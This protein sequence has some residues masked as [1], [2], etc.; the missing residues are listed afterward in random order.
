MDD[1][2]SPVPQTDERTRV[3]YPQTTRK[4]KRFKKRVWLPTKARMIAAREDLTPFP[5]D[6]P[7]GILRLVRDIVSRLCP[8]AHRRI[9]G[10]AIMALQVSSEDLLTEV[11]T[12]MPRSRQPPFC[13]D[14]PLAWTRSSQR[15]DLTDDDIGTFREIARR[16][17]EHNLE[18]SKKTPNNRTKGC[19][20]GLSTSCRD[21]TPRRRVP[22]EP[23]ALNKERRKRKLLRR[24]GFLC[25]LSHA[26]GSNDQLE[27][28]N[29]P[30]EGT[31]SG[32]LTICPQGLPMQMIQDK[33]G[34]KEPTNGCFCSEYEMSDSNDGPPINMDQERDGNK[35]PI[36]DLLY[37]DYEMSD[38]HAASI[39]A[40]MRN[41]DK[42]SDGSE[43][44]APSTGSYEDNHDTA[45][46]MLCKITAPQQRSDDSN[47]ETS[48]SS[49]DNS[50]QRIEASGAVQS[51]HSV[52]ENAPVC[53][54]MLCHSS[55]GEV[56][57]FF[58]SGGHESEPVVK[59]PP[60]DKQ[61]QNSSYDNNWGQTGPKT[62]M[63]KRYSPLRESVADK[64]EE[65]STMDPKDALASQYRP[66][67]DR[68]G[69]EYNTSIGGE[70]IP[71]SWEYPPQPMLPYEGHFQDE[72]A[73]I[74]MSVAVEA[75]EQQPD[76]TWQSPKTSCNNLPG[77]VVQDDQFHMTTDHHQRNCEGCVPKEIDTEH[78]CWQDKTLP[79]AVAEDVDKHESEEATTSTTTMLQSPYTEVEHL[80]IGNHGI[81][82]VDS[83]NEVDTGMVGRSIGA[84]QTLSDFG[85]HSTKAEDEDSS[86]EDTPEIEFYI[87][88]LGG[89]TWE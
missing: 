63:L 45:S 10:W 5:S 59:S 21:S 34:N 1:T 28:A 68:I 71:E 43:A 76:S 52:Q 17:H 20:S 25:T 57:I 13:A 32:Q 65:A 86:D 35:E 33:D 73:T 36:N 37:S 66:T 51:E 58:Q 11:F 81:E 82:K 7:D 9:T 50:T 67:G 64:V 77:V 44:R 4:P 14:Y 16:L 24:S 19:P 23:R 29:H 78:H 48:V 60:H 83:H 8:P 47:G 84:T 56:D 80:D 18:K 53:L 26:C 41:A 12:G 85:S 46:N 89:E 61:I 55:P 88:D 74:E 30:F 22:S 39:L 79:L 27:D 72:F 75:P 31:L 15:A 70:H 42:S 40:Y 69:F 3:Q 2:G 38:S 6:G 49:V 62:E 87:N 54:R